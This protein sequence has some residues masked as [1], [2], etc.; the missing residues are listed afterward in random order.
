VTE[1]RRSD[2]GALLEQCMLDAGMTQGAFGQAMGVSQPQ[3]FR[4][5]TGDGDPSFEERLR[6]AQVFKKQSWQFLSEGQRA[7]VGAL[8]VELVKA[9]DGPEAIRR[10]LVC[11]PDLDEEALAAIKE[12]FDQLLRRE[13]GCSLEDLDARSQAALLEKLRRPDRSA[14]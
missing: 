2:L 12:S 7:G 14:G 6:M 5:L 10:A 1:K 9:K 8:L 4:W 3:V 11:T 13:L